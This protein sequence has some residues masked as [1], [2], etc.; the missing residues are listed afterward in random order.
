[1][2]SDKKS[3]HVLQSDMC[4]SEAILLSGIPPKQLIIYMELIFLG[5]SDKVKCLDNGQQVTA[6]EFTQAAKKYVFRR[7]TTS[8]HYS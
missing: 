3:V 2:L 6:W 7:G 4:F 8:F 5:A 1:M